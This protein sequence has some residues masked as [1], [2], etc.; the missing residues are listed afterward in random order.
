MSGDLEADK[1]LGCFQLRMTWI[2][3]PY[4]IQWKH[5]SCSYDGQVF[6]ASAADALDRPVG[7]VLLCIADAIVAVASRIVVAGRIAPMQHPVVGMIENGYV[8]VHMLRVVETAVVNVCPFFDR[9]THDN[10]EFHD[11]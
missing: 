8:C 9:C 11:T 5:Q 10:L 1:D 2:Y 7:S 4:T 6:E 3:L